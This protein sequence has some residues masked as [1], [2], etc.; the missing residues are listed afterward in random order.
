[1]RTPLVAGNWKM[2]LTSAQGEALITE[3]IHL[4]GDRLPIDVAV[5]PAYLSIPRVA[6]VCRRSAIK[7]G[8]QDC[9]WADFGAFTGNVSPVQ[10]AEF[11]VEYCIVGHSETR[12]RF[13]KLETP[14]STIPYFSESEATIN[15]KLKALFFQGITPILCVGETLAEREANLTD[16]VIANQL[17]GALEGIESAEMYG[18]VIAYEPVWAIGTGKTCDTAE[19]ERV[20]AAIR[21]V[22]STL[23]DQETAE[24]VRILYGGSVKPDNAADLFAQSNIDGGLVGGASL[25]AKSFYEVIKATH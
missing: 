2:N 10:L 4:V 9:L 25:D 1:M 19:A 13:G 18:L 22:L 16:Q 17:Q 11:H 5:C 23:A 14:E 3:L 20:C 8:A 12:G 7:L 21:N 24:N 6:E 15:L